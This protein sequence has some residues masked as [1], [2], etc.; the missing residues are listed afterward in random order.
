MNAWRRRALARALL[1]T[2][3]AL[4][5]CGGGDD[6]NDDHRDFQVTALVVDRVSG[7]PYTA[8]QTDARLVNPWGI[9]FDPQGFVVVANAETGT[10]TRY[11][12][13][14]I[15]QSP[16]VTVPTGSRGSGG[17]TGIVFSGSDDFVVTGPSGTG[18]SR[19]VFA[20]EGGTLAAWS[21]EANPT[22]AIT[23]VDGGAEERIYK[24]LALQAGPG[25]GMRLYATDFHNAR[26]DVFDAEFQPV[27]V[28]GGFGDPNLPAGYAPFGIQA[29]G[30][31]LLVSFARQ[32][33]EAEDDVKGDGFGFV[34]LFTNDGVLVRR[35]ITQG[36]LNAPWG[37]AVAPDGFGRFGGAL[38][39]GNFGD[40]RINAYDPDNG[41]HLGELSR[42][43][44]EPIEIEGLWGI[45]FGNGIDEQPT[46]TLFFAAGPGDEEHGVYGRIDVD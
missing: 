39:V 15:P 1:A 36:R 2:T 7:N 24:G 33:D 31:R 4:A 26:V 14:G 25:G 34:D 30:D 18:P 16:V 22:A 9:A 3:L 21:P 13:R 38:L 28:A 46:D 12:G 43:N 44:G 27:L 5:G 40:G 17:P 10:A 37:M 19:L 29:F 6:D 11:D 23:V 32:D 8:M 41:R 20:T 42:P 35:L 45:A